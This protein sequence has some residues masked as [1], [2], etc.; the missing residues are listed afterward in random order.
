VHEHQ[1]ETDV[2]MCAVSSLCPV[3]FSSTEAHSACPQLCLSP[4]L[5]H[6]DRKSVESDVHMSTVVKQIASIAAVINVISVSFYTGQCRT[7]ELQIIPC[8][9]VCVCV[10]CQRKYQSFIA[11][12]VAK[13]A[14]A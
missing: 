3:A 10:Y 4:S 9:S 11:Y 1:H 8:N 13:A 2:C 12:K 6:T 14:T 5:T 7:P